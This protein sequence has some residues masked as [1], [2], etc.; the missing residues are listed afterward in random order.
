MK[1][2]VFLEKYYVFERKIGREN[3][4]FDEQ[5]GLPEKIASFDEQTDRPPG[6]LVCVRGT[7]KASWKIS[8]C[9]MYR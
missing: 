8:M 9:S 5:T 2:Y 3:N 7:N 6:K 1:K 4:V